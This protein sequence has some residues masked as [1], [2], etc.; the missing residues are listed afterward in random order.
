MPAIPSEEQHERHE[1]SQTQML[2]DR[3]VAFDVRNQPLAL[4][5]SLQVLPVLLKNRE[6]NPILTNPGEFYPY[7]SQN[8][9][10]YLGSLLG[11]ARPH[12]IVSN[13]PHLN[14][15]TADSLCG[16]GSRPYVLSISTLALGLIV[17]W[18]A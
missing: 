3:A 17:G 4:V 11:F 12:I 2:K 6:R 7:V 8:A 15:L 5:A 9:L 18:G 16:V 1:S 13:V 10:S 14:C